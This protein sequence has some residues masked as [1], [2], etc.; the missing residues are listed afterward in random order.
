MKSFASV[1]G[2]PPARGRQVSSGSVA[3]DR[4]CNAILGRTL[5]FDDYANLV[6]AP[7]NSTVAVQPHRRDGEEYTGTLDQ[8]IEI[9]VEHP[10]FL[11]WTP[12]P[13]KNEI[14]K[15][16]FSAYLVRGKTGPELFI[17]WIRLPDHAPRGT[18]AALI[19]RM[20][21][22]AHTQRIPAIA[23]DADRWDLTGMV[24]Y[25]VFPLYGFDRAIPTVTQKPGT[26]DPFHLQVPLP[27]ELASARTMRELFML[28]GGMAWWKAN[29][30]C[31]SGARMSTD[32]NAPSA[33][34]LR[35]FVRT[36]SPSDAELDAYIRSLR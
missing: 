11:P 4:L 9:T 15:S 27:P 23:M 35:Q 8:C 13:G 25:F 5:S 18:G 10:L 2:L 30:C 20:R 6:A 19:E 16:T 14:Y 3:V 24:G 32:P 22:E 34:V 7:P 1:A 21:R 12:P 28:P 29:G 36:R 17:N 26:F 31:L 33:R